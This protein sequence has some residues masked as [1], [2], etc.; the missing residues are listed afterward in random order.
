MSSPIKIFDLTGDLTGDFRGLKVLIP[1]EI[2]K[3]PA[4]VLSTAFANRSG[5]T[6]IDFTTNVSTFGGLTPSDLSL[7]T[8]T[9]REMNNAVGTHP[10]D[11]TDF[12]ETVYYL[13][14]FNGYDGPFGRPIPVTNAGLNVPSDMPVHYDTDEEALKQMPYENSKLA[15]VP[16][17]DNGFIDNILDEVITAIANN[18]PEVA[19]IYHLSA[20]AP[21][22][23]TWTQRGVDVVDTQVD[24]TDVTK[25][26][27]QKTAANSAPA[28]DDRNLVAQKLS[29]TDFVGLEEMSD[30]QIEAFE[31]AL[32]ARY[33]YMVAENEIG[34]Y[35]LS[36]SAP[37]IGGTWQQLG[38]T[39]TDQLKDTA[40]Y[41]YEG[42]YT[43]SYT[44]YYDGTYSG[45]FD[46]TYDGTY[47]ANYSG[48]LGT[49]YTGSYTGSYTGAYTGTYAGSYSGDYTGYYDGVTV[50]STSSTQESKKLF[51]RTI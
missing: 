18:L 15:D 30:A 20:S 23:G 38:E 10:V 5:N 46:G 24:G 45:T 41:A 16:F 7:G 3:K 43:G 9:N 1:T 33:V 11:P 19:G 40:T 6:L 39:L 26:L 37:T 35:R 28:S 21:A 48:F 49:A 17:A 25:K 27:W 36:T 8:F 47:Q 4:N 14:L 34:S 2:R 29:G 13:R 32:Y 44:G 22:S 50:I 51:V 31:L 12:S 42:S